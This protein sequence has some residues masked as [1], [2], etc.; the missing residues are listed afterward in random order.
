MIKFEF[1]VSEIDAENIMSLF[2][3]DVN[4]INERIMDEM[5]SDRV[6]SERV[7]QNY[8]EQIV[9]M[10]ELKDKVKNHWVKE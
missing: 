10:R 1:V 5:C 9:Y 6:D 7:I 8:R 2:Q 4:R 3:S